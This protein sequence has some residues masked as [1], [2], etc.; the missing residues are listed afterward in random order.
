MSAVNQV[1]AMGA[2]LIGAFLTLTVPAAAHGGGHGGM[3]GF[4]GSSAAMGG[5]FGG[6]GLGTL[7]WIVVIGLVAVLAFG[8][9]RSDS[10]P[11]SKSS[12]GVSRQTN[13]MATLRE[14][15]ARGEL[16]EDEFQ[17][18]RQTLSR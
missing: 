16:S 4:S 13:A 3:G 10:T 6:A 7:L 15:Y 8:Y 1:V 12:D 5:T 14:R 11:T 2:A 18:R 17:R 9:L